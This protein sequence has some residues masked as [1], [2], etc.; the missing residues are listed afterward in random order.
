[1]KEIKSNLC[2]ILSERHHKMIKNYI[3]SEIGFADDNNDDDD[4]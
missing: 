2:S 4:E 1:M 3:D